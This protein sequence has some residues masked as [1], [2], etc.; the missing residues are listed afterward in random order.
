LVYFYQKGKIEAALK[1]DPAVD[2]A[3]TILK[4]NSTYTAILSGIK[5]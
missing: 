5:K 4:D 1:N 3:I 2:E